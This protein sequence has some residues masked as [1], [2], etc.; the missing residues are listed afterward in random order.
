[1]A[2]SVRL[3]HPKA[4]VRKL[5]A[6]TTGMEQRVRS[7]GAAPFSERLSAQWITDNELPGPLRDFIVLGAGCTPVRW[8]GS[9]ALPYL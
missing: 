3:L 8:Y 2:Q 4:S 6:Q 1:V 5:P 7:K 9:S